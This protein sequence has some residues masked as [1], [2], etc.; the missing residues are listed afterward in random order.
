MDRIDLDIDVLRTLVTAQD[1]GGFNRAAAQLGRSQSAISL[2]MRKLEEQIGQKLL[3][4]DGRGLVVT[5][6]GEMALRYAREMVALND[7]AVAALRGAAVEGAVRFGMPSD[8]AE[9]WLP[10]TLGQF[11]RAYG[12]VQIEASVDRN[13]KLLERLDR[14]ELDLALSFG[15]SARADAQVIA[16]MP[17]VWIGPH[18][19][20]R[21]WRV[22]FTS[23]SLPGLW[24]AVAAGLGITI[25]MPPGVP[26]HLRILGRAEGL[27]KLPMVD[28]SLHDA[29]RKL[30]PAA[31]HLRETLLA[32][33]PPSLASPPR[34]PRSAAALPA[35]SRRTGSR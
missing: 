19:I 21:K 3:R 11:K 18:A 35:R 30:S 20:K 29:G 10:E 9:T 1:L 2:R 25:R 16:T 13:F 7:R 23:P 14:G 4:K 24:A 28:L 15:A 31:Q 32:T 5:G 6:A 34:S 33:L 8:F 22:T 27:P 12:A 17:M 26:S